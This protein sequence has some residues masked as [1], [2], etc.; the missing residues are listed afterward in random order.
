MAGA[1]V[2]YDG[3]PGAHP[4]TGLFVPDLDL[5]TASGPVRLADLAHEAPPLLLD[6][7][8]DTGLQ[9]VAARWKDRVDLVVAGCPRPPAS[10]PLVRPDGYVAWAGEEHAGLERALTRWFGA[11]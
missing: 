6:L 1:D 4:L 7:T 3:E 9:A 5:V 2:R 10:G 8:G 11:G